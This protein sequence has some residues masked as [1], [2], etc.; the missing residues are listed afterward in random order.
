MR[1]ARHRARPFPEECRGGAVNGV[2]PT[3]MVLDLVGCLARRVDWIAGEAVTP[4]AAVRE[5][6]RAR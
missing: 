1:F 5:H 6:A 4:A 2:G 3:L